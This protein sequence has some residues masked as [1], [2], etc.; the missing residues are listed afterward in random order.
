MLAGGSTV[1]SD[2]LGKLG[3][4]LRKMYFRCLRKALWYPVSVG[5]CSLRE[6]LAQEIVQFHPFDHII[7]LTLLLSLQ[8]YFFF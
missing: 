3:G 6:L 4:A 1:L 8:Y 2:F 5:H 7:F